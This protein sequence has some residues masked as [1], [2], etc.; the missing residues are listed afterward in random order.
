[1]KQSVNYFFTRSKDTHQEQDTRF[2]TLFVRLT[3]EHTETEPNAGLQKIESM[4]VEI[5]ELEMRQADRKLQALPNGVS[6]YVISKEVFDN[7][8]QVAATCPTALYY[9]TPIY[10]SNDFRK[11]QET[12]ADRV[13]A[14]S[15]S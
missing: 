11:F 9:L 6:R 10:K 14:D 3:K 7:L 8:I 1:M 4:W 12:C 2:I 5:E 13:S 15:L